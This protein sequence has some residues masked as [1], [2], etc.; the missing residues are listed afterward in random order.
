[1]NYEDDDGKLATGAQ[2]ENLL[3]KL[4]A[5]SL[6]ELDPTHDLSHVSERVTKS[7]E[8]G[9]K[10]LI[11]ESHVDPERSRVLWTKQTTV[12]ELN[13]VIHALQMIRDNIKEQL[14]VRI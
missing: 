11:S 3:D 7:F 4:L 12:E 8:T 1:M 13:V 10:A 9:V 2:R 6:L 5:G 14:K